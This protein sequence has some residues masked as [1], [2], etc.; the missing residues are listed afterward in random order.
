MVKK[1]CMKNVMVSLI[2][3]IDSFN[4]LLKDHHRRTAIIAY[5]LGNIYGLD[6]HRMDDLILAA[7]LHDI[8]ALYVSERDQLIQAD[9]DNP[10]DHEVNGAKMLEGFKPFESIAKIIGH[11][12]IKYE[13]VLLGLVDASEVPLESYVLHLADRIDVLLLKYGNDHPRVIEEIKL[14]FGTVFA[15]FLLD[16]FVKATEN[17][18]FWSTISFDSFHDLLMRSLDEAHYD[19]DGEGIESL[20]RLFAHI[21]DFRSP[22]TTRHSETVS[23]LAYR[24]GQLMGF[25][26]DACWELRISGYL[27]DIGKIAIPVEL[28]DKP[29]KLTA[30]EFERVKNHV[31]YST[32]ILSPISEFENIVNL[33]SNH[34]EKRD[35]SGYPLKPKEEAFSIQTD[36]LAF[37]D[38]FAALSENRPYRAGMIKEE[39]IDTLAEFTPDKLSENVYKVILE[40]FDELLG[41]AL[42]TKVE[43]VSN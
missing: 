2:K 38:I 40:H 35:R 36:V 15:P 29:G 17:I 37:A 6:K 41:I 5:Q 32:L 19:I 4:Y 3:S 10:R 24:L 8:G 28:I 7:S 1:I 30:D 31:V 11:H 34:H 12:H 16:T 39:I 26:E 27:H 14:R 23:H 20:A 13:S 21:I 42:H 9:V 33:A 22:W 18:E 25:S 43:P